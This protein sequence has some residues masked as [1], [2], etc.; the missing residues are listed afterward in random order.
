MIM[1]GA[2]EGNQTVARHLP[3]LRKTSPLNQTFR[4][5]PNGQVIPKSRRW[6][7]AI[8]GNGPSGVEAPLYDRT[9]EVW[10]VN[11]CVRHCF[12]RDGEFRADRWFEIHDLAE[13]VCRKRRPKG[14]I[15]WLR[16]FQ[17][18]LY[19]WHGRHDAKLS[20]QYPLARV[21]A[22]GPDYF[23]CTFAYQV[24]LA[25]AEGFTTIGLFGAELNYGREA[26]VERPTVERWIGIA[27][28]KNIEVI[29]P[30]SYPIGLGRHPYR[31]AFDQVHERNASFAFCRQHLQTTLDYV[32]SRSE[33]LA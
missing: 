9:W 10:G 20:V 25:I 12:T 33:G 31:Y 23:A 26:L 29:I 32:C 24:A 22:V 13:R 19:Q 7:V 5:T 2:V 16:Q 8:V 21:L 30:T 17:I 14:F 1:N 27:Q 18:P 11:G 6:K 28:G 3:S 15:P 4:V